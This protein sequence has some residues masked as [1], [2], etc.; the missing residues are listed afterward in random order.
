MSTHDDV[1]GMAK[2]ATGEG[3][4]PHRAGLTGRVRASST[5]EPGARWR[6]PGGL[7]GALILVAACL[8][9]VPVYAASQVLKVGVLAQGGTETCVRRW[10]ATTQY[11]TAHVA[12]ESFELVPLGFGE[13]YDAVRQRRVDFLLVDPSVY[14][15]LE[16]RYGAQ[17]IATLKAKM[18]DDTSTKCAGV[19]FTKAGAG[20]ITRFRDLAGTTFVAV[21]ERSLGGWLAAYRELQDS[22]IDPYEDFGQLRFTGTD[23]QVVHEV[24]SGQAAAGTVTTGTLERMAAEGRIALTAF[25]VLRGRDVSDE[26]LHFIHST[27]AYPEWPFAKLAHTPDDQAKRVAITLLTMPD[28]CTAAK[29]ANCAGWTI[30]EDYQ[31]VHQC[32]MELRLPPYDHLGQITFAA[33]VRQYWGWLIV[34]SLVFAAMATFLA[35]TRRL[36]RSLVATQHRLEAEIAA[37]KRTEGELREAKDAAEEADRAKSTFLANMSHELRTP[38]NAVIGYSEMLQEEAEGS[39]HDS[40]TP[41]LQRINA[42]GKHLLVLINDVLDLSKI[43][44]GKMELF[45]ET[46]DVRAM[47]DEVLAT[48]QPL[49]APNGNELGLRCAEDLGEM[50]SDLTRVR[51]CLF[52]LLSNACKFTTNGTVTVTAARDL[53]EGRDWLTFAVVDSGIGMNP[54]Q[55]EGV[56]E[57]FVQVEAST[58]RRFEGT[59]LGLAITRT[60]CQMMGGEITIESE[61][62]KGSTFTLALP[63]DMATAPERPAA[64]A[65]ERSARPVLPEDRDTVLVIDDDPVARDLLGRF[66]EKE[67]FGVQTADG[68]EEGLRLAKELRPAIITLDVL[69]PTTDGWAVLA[70]LK[71][72]PDV[73]DVPVVMITM[74]DDRKTGLALGASDFLTKP[75]Q[76]GRLRTI[77]A[78]HRPRD[79]LCRVL[80]VEDRE[81]DRA[82]LTR[83]LERDGCEV[84]EAENGRVALERMAETRPTLILLDIMMPEMDGFEFVDE[85]RKHHEWR[86]IPI[87][88]VTAKDLTAEDHQ[89]LDGSVA[90][91]VRKGA[92]AREELRREIDIL[93]GPRAR[94]TAPDEQEV[95]DGQDPGGRGQR[96]EPGHAH[97][98]SGP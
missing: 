69:M 41:D 39:G 83:M 50:R 21:H 44:A 96:D 51:Q 64:A 98:P 59:G 57:A 90:R 29:A 6:P 86:R 46:F 76:W 40:Y 80:V 52:N 62:G 32:L 91:I 79:R 20:E 9:I 30:P 82:M 92:D 14:V 10:E 34:G 15:D 17:R 23:E 63:A 22:G 35:H 16:V 70:A 95:S 26:G 60:F 36:N 68:G 45:V 24:S 53:K 25:R 54:E 31:P 33:V 4:V 55:T 97:S 78:R 28:N 1:Q 42:A 93:L 47:I 94:R 3:A 77:L 43:E 74:L 87:V 19:I 2:R 73:G 65:P 18:L 61:P 7:S 38:L 67:G 5:G 81:G 13:V 89:R 11:L 75:I 84:A 88:V 56:F 58:T 12:S 66:L 72:D 49:A 27:R 85:F 48:V 37:R 8:A 71:S